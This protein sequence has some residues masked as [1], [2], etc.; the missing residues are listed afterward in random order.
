MKDS[1]FLELLNLYLDH[2]IEA[3]DAARL[4]TEVQSNPARRRVYQEYCRMQ[5]ACTMLAKDFVDQQSPKKLRTLE[6]QRSWGPM[7][8]GGAGLAAA[9]CVALV[10]TYRTSTTVPDATAS[11]QSVAVAQ[12]VTIPVVAATAPIAPKPE[13][14]TVIARAVTVQP[15]MVNETKAFQPSVPITLTSG[16]AAATAALLANA[17][18]N[19]QAVAQQDIKAELEWL[20]NFQIAPIQQMPLA[21]MQ[22]DARPAQQ[23]ANRTF[24]GN[25]SADAS[26][27]WTAFRLHDK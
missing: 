8:L 13:G 27:E 6:P 26:V 20:K 1:E 5:K 17:Q 3:S 22:L 11:G 10:V 14:S 7:W 21:D 19:M 18:R 15:V 24:T 16:N 2:E 12:G 23:V 4:E 9:A 25:R